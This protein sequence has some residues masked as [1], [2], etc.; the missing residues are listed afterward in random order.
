MGWLDRNHYHIDNG[1]TINMTCSI[2]VFVIRYLIEIIIHPDCNRS[3]INTSNSSY[4]ISY[5]QLMVMLG[6]GM[7]RT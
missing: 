3:I 2:H 4:I 1:I 7:A 5:K 6:S